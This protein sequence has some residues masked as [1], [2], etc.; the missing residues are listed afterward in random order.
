[1]PALGTK[2]ESMNLIRIVT[3]GWSDV[4]LIHEIPSERIWQSSTKRPFGPANGK[5]NFA[6]STGEVETAIRSYFQAMNGRR[7][8]AQWLRRRLRYR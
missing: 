1:M 8:E 3:A 4:V 5:V 7:K 2:S 6:V